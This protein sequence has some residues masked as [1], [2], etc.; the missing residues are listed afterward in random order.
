MCVDQSINSILSK[1]NNVYSGHNFHCFFNSQE[2]R[3]ILFQGLEYIFKNREEFT[4]CEICAECTTFFKD[5][6]L[7]IRCLTHNFDD[8]SYYGKIIHKLDQ[9]NF[10]YFGVGVGGG[11]VS[12]VCVK[13]S[14][15]LLGG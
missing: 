7:S 3:D 13:E 15:R 8:S 4:K 1:Y 12:K 14:F 6:E 10:L 2:N 5:K 11:K 9:N